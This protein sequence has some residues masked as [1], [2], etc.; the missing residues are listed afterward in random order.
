[1][2]RTRQLSYMQPPLSEPILAPS[3]TPREGRQLRR[4]RYEYNWRPLLHRA[5]A[6][7]PVLDAAVMVPE[8]GPDAL[9]NRP[10][11]EADST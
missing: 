4:P 11:R 3:E 7:R 5:V 9:G 8:G 2:V 10:S 1:M 6:L